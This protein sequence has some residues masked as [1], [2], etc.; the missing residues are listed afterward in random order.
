MASA[1]A[2]PHVAVEVDWLGVEATGGCPPTL[3]LFSFLFLF[4]SPAMAT[5]L[6]MA[7]GLIQ[8]SEGGFDG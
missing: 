1:V 7:P 6:V 3:N 4:L 8:A 5:Q 2:T